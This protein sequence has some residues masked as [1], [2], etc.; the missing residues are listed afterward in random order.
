M[1]GL[2]GCSRYEP[3]IR[4]GAKP[5]PM[6]TLQQ[7]SDSE[8]ALNSDFEK[9]IRSINSADDADAAIPKI[10]AYIEDRNG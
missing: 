3:N 1:L 6:R 10:S 8:F 7:I 4:T 5:S 2:A 9:V